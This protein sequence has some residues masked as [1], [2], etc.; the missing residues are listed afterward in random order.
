MEIPDREKLGIPSHFEAA[1]GAYVLRPYQ[2]GKQ[3]MGTIFVQGT[4]VVYSILSLLPTL[5]QEGLN[6]K[7]VCVTSTELFE[8]QSREYQDQVLTDADHADSTFF[9]TQSRRMMSAWAFNSV[10]E[11]Y[12]LSSDHDDRWRTGGTLDEV[13]DEAH[14]SPKW[15][16][17]AI[18]S[19]AM[20]REKRLATLSQQ[21]ASAKQ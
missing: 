8:M 5:G 11:Q 18:R 16:L 9:T 10:S 3:R 20:D 17:E 14:M 6:V 21:L 12:C 4:S 13:L 1:K 2:E 15:V 7:I 19:F